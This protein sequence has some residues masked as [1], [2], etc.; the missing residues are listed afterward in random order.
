M[1]WWL[2]DSEGIVAFWLL[3]FA[4]CNGLRGAYCWF[5]DKEERRVV[6]GLLASTPHPVRASFLLGG[7]A[8]AAETA[9]CML[10]DDGVVKVSS[11]GELRPT[12]R[13]RKQTDHALRALAEGIRATPSGATTRLHEIPTEARFTPFR[14]LVERR[15]PA[16]RATASGKSQSLMLATS[17]L[18]TFAMGV[19]AGGALAPTAFFPETPRMSWLYVCMAAWLVQWGPACLWP[20]EKRRRWK[21]LDTLCEDE[22]EIARAALPDSTRRAIALTR[23]RPE[24]PPPPPGPA[25][26]HTRGDT[27]GACGAGIDVDSCNSGSSCGGCGGCGGE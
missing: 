6:E 13:G 2:T 17:M 20:S 1:D 7:V 27:G 4:V 26:H 25:R 12:H 15:A 23:Q 5:R 10:V 22:T 16:V 9:V 11:T 18:T 14:Q 24:P 21:A 19:H 3:I 8:E